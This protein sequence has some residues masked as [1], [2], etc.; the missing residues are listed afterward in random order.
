MRRLACMIWLVVIGCDS[1]AGEDA[2]PDGEPSVATATDNADAGSVGESASEPSSYAPR[3]IEIVD[4]DGRRAGTRAI[5]FRPPDGRV[6]ATASDDG[7]IRV[8][9]PRGSEPVRTFVS[10]HGTLWDIA[11]VGDAERLVA[12]VGNGS[13]RMWDIAS[14]DSLATFGSGTVM[15]LAPVPGTPLVVWTSSMLGLSLW[16]TNTMADEGRI[17]LGSWLHGLAVSPDGE[18][19]AVASGEG[20]VRLWNIESRSQV[21][22]YR[23]HDVSNAVAFSADGT[24][25]YAGG[26]T[27]RRLL[28]LD[29]ETGALVGAVDVGAGIQA[30]A[31]DPTGRLVATAGGRRI[32]L[33]DAR[34]FELI[35]AID[36]LVGN[37]IQDLAFSGDGAKL[38]SADMEGVLIWDVPDA[39][40]AYPPEALP[41]GLPLGRIADCGSDG[42]ELRFAGTVVDSVSGLAVDSAEVTID[43]CRL[44]TD[45][46]G[47][48]DLGGLPFEDSLEVRIWKRGYRTH[49]DWLRPPGDVDLQVMLPPRLRCDGSREAPLPR[50]ETVDSAVILRLPPAMQAALDEVAPDFQPQ[51]LS[52]FVYYNEQGYGYACYQ[53]PSAVI[54][55]FN[56]DGSADLVVHGR[57]AGEGM[58]VMLISSPGGYTSLLRGGLIPA[59][60]HLSRVEP[61]TYAGNTMDVAPLRLSTQG[62]LQSGEM[63][64]YRVIYYL[65][66]E[67][68]TWDYPFL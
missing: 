2:V 47:A 28:V 9:S 25:L 59:G 22:T 65:D 38:G 35:A 40:E 46:L 61:G 43:G 51:P 54:G 45:G 58:G 18:A 23:H 24:R 21:W 48:F 52:D 67:I 49:A 56:G 8:W 60:Q 31:V 27:G 26:R 37:Q 53:A 57:A 64:V 63:Y 44:L 17:D 12:S 5:A 55:D 20:Y 42:G 68:L 62:V 50:V 7:L 34:S 14:G 1:H 39:I 11:F 33:W 16:N 41:P 66:G 36:S 13:A 15:G 3:Q 4:E 10:P 6:V 32:R 29:R 30:M 19:A